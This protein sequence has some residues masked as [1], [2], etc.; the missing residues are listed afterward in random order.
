MRKVWAHLV[1]FVVDDSTTRTEKKK[2]RLV[3]SAV[4]KKKI[5]FTPMRGV[6][7]FINS[8][9]YSTECNNSHVNQV[10]ATIFLLV[11]EMMFGHRTKRREQQHHMDSHDSF[12][13]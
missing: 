13:V 10:D 11:V 2:Q 12:G 8:I 3:L 5:A 1:V 4:Q 7:N 6:S 9:H